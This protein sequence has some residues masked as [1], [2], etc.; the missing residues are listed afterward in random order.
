MSR[1]I[2]TRLLLALVVATNAGV[3]VWAKDP[4]GAA[5]KSASGLPRP[6]V[7]DEVA[8]RVDEYLTRCVPFGF[9]GVLLLTKGGRVVLKKGYGYA[10]RKRRIPFTP[11]TLYNIESVT[12]Q[13]TAA[14][15]L[16]LEEQG[17]LSTGDP[18]TKYFDGV[19]EDKSRITL[20]QL[21]THTAGLQGMNGDDDEV[22]GREAAVRRILDSRLLSAPGGK[23]SYSNPGYTLLTVIVEKVSGKSYEA[24]VR[25]QLLAPAGMADTGYATQTRKRDRI[26]RAYS[27]A[28]DLGAPPEHWAPDGPWWNLRGAGG[29]LSTVE[30]M[31][32]WHLA[33]K[34]NLVLSEA[35]QRKAMTP[36][37]PTVRP[38]SS[39]GYAWFVT[40]A[41]NGKPL[42]EHGGDGM[43]MAEFRRYLGD[44][45]V[46]ILG[47]NNKS[48][49][50]VNQPV[51]R[52]A[53][54]LLN[55]AQY[56]LP[57]K[58]GAALPP[59]ELRKYAGT[60]AL[61]SGAEFELV[62]DGDRLFVDTT[63]PG[64]AALLTR[65]PD[66]QDA[67][68]LRELDPVIK[69]VVGGIDRGD[70]DPFRQVLWRDMKFEEERDYWASTWP[71]WEKQYGAYTG[72][73]VLGSYP[74]ADSP[75]VYVLLNFERAARLVRFQRNAGGQL[76]INNM[77]TPLLPP[78]YWFAPQSKGRFVS[79][80]FGTSTELR[81]E[82]QTGEAGSVVTLTS[83]GAANN[84]VAKRVR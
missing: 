11:R 83:P 46:F 58:A 13:F 72:A 51:R 76:F 37:S 53:V 44:D 25:E 62:A 6:D 4:D 3:G 29:L 19:P 49:D 32:R 47:I 14:A 50:A 67:G 60:Y 20:H 80:N 63:K 9:S 23:W 28:E 57:P 81:L 74:A 61:P 34:N 78:F 26:A 59:A 82:F 75:D 54:K 1:K 68:R 15:I 69:G 52:Q 70:F 30:D 21:L 79:Y 40:K 33:L 48:R 24:F 45:M 71:E 8:A 43:F 66:A 2:T 31:Y 5:L 64:A 36:H 73:S 7:R 56:S 41:P 42:V 18:I 17:R 39:Y 16:K 38:Q 35:S 77:Q 27:G 65:L 12:K 22:I 55:D 10:D 84:P